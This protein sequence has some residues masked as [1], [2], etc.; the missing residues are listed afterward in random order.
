MFAKRV[1]LEDGEIDEEQET[2]H[3]N[4]DETVQRAEH[5]V[6][7]V[8]DGNVEKANAST[9]QYRRPVAT[10]SWWSVSQTKW[11]DDTTPRNKY[12]WTRVG[13]AQELG[14]PRAGDPCGPCVLSGDTAT[15][16]EHPTHKACGRCLW[17]KR[18]SRCKVSA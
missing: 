1:K 13:R 7:A 17:N 10:D 2:G 11:D 6:L 5:E 18:E 12:R 8:E 3:D 14:A 9:F 4:P 15:C 16:F